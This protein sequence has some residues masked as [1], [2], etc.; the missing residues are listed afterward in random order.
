MP[1]DANSDVLRV[2]KEVWLIETKCNKAKAFRSFSVPNSSFLLTGETSSQ[3]VF[4]WF[5][6]IT[7]LP[8]C[9]LG[10]GNDSKSV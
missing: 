10:A 5:V 8:T 7:A 1:V 3:Q 2:S 6:R 4:D 9:S